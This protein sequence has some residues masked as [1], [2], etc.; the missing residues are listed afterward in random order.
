MSKQ[1][2]KQDKP[3]K[4]A[5]AVE[6]PPDGIR[7]IADFDL[8]QDWIEAQL[9][10]LEARPILVHGDWYL[11]DKVT[12]VWEKHGNEVI[13]LSLADMYH[14]KSYLSKGKI[15]VFRLSNGKWNAIACCTHPQCIANDFFTSDARPRIGFLDG[16]MIYEQG[17]EKLQR[18]VHDP[19]NRLR[20]KYDCT[21]EEMQ[22]TKCDDFHH[23]LEDILP[24]EKIRRIIQQYVGMC[25]LGAGT[26]LQ[27]SLIF[28]GEGDN[29][30]ST[31]LDIIEAIFPK[32]SVSTVSPSSIETDKYQVTS[33]EGSLINLV[34]EAPGA[35]MKSTEAWKS[36]VSGGVVPARKPYGQPFSFRP[37]AG[38]IYCANNLPGTRDQSKGYWK[39]LVPI[40]FSRRLTA[41]EIDTELGR[42]IL[43]N[44]LP[45]II[46]W[47]IQGAEEAIKA[48]WR[49]DT[50]DAGIKAVLQEWQA[51]SDS[52]RGW[53]ETMEVDGAMSKKSWVPLRDLFDSFRTWCRDSEHRPCGWMKFRKRLEQT[54]VE[55]TRSQGGS[56]VAPVYELS[57]TQRAT[58]PDDASQDSIFG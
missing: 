17:A 48:K 5:E 28:T 11:Y 29:G 1:Q 23:F 22:E 33:L 50:D 25:L 4:E 13:M 44:E 30:K 7:S 9:D 55:V 42:R 14:G 24:S 38:H 56:Y 27:K 19:L 41:E 53:L 45:G 57:K 6:L 39:R 26:K 46:R 20:H 49:I 3:G 34:D 51:E 2:D 15:K 37:I 36:I 40:P 10:L 12:G 18:V 52:I 35:D 21:L 58:T 54:G 8:A 31:L 32:G 47:A 16:A 43:E